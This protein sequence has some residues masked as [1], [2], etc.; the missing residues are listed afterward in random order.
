[1]NPT[2]TQL[3][4]NLLNEVGAALD[5]LPGT[6]RRFFE[7]R[8]QNAAQGLAQALATPSDPGAKQ[9]A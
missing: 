2:P 8:I 1:M 4:Q 6:Q 5:E 7:K 9:Q 3:L